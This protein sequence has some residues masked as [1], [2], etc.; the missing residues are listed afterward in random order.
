[1]EGICVNFLNLVQF[2]RFLKGRCHGNQLKSK[3]QRLLRTN[4]F[5]RTAIQKRIAISQFQFQRIRQN[6][7]LY[8]VYNCGDIRSRKHRDYADNNST[9][10]GD[11]VKI[12][13]SRQISHNVLD[14]P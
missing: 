6:E 3:N 5:C 7:P 11:M 4:L 2:F 14:L 9:L 13:I 12:G 8:I 10:C 1:M